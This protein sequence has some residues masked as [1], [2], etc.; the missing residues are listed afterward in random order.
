MND[1]Q[2]RMAFHRLA[3]GKDHADLD[4]FVVDEFGIQHGKIR[5]DIAVINGQLIGYE[6]KSDQDSLNRLVGQIEGYSAVFDRIFLVTS[7]RHLSHALEILPPDWGVIRADEVFPGAIQFRRI[8]AAKMNPRVDDYSVTQLLW[9]EEAL[10]LLDTLGV[11]EPIRS[12]PRAEL[13]QLLV[14]QVGSRALRQMVRGCL[15]ERLAQPP[16]WRPI[17]NG[18]SSPLAAKG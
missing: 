17:L 12:K 9:R 5:A 3:L 2:I 10:R 16:P 4:T 8:R 15:K 7:P 18:D 13:Y 1:I 11:R 6:I 14:E